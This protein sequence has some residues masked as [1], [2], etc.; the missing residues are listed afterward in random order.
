M[1]L[2]KLTEFLGYFKDRPFA[3][4]VWV[5]PAMVTYIHEWT[6][7]V[8]R[9]DKQDPNLGT[10]KEEMTHTVI[11]FATGLHEEA[12]AI[13]VIETPEVIAWAICEARP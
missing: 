3:R 4:D 2:I 13:T 11:S 7:D 10:P 9:Y 6:R 8:Y 1:M 12:D 5:N